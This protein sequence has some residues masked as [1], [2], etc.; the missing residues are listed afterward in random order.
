MTKNVNGVSEDFAASEKYSSEVKEIIAKNLIIART[1]NN[2]TQEELAQRA[3]I[4]RYT[5][6]QIENGEGDPKL[7]T[8]SDIASA[9][10]FSVALLFLGENE[11][12]AIQ[13][14]NNEQAE[15]FI[16][17]NISPEE[18]KQLNK[19]SKSTLQK[20]HIKAA[21]MGVEAAQKGGLVP[22]KNSEVASAAAGAAAGAAIG[23]ILLPGI[24]TAIGAA[25]GSLFFYNFNNKPSNEGDKKGGS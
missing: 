25:I 23:T 6:V 15:K 4:S 16:N 12:K 17:E 5:I 21:R 20:N 9:L 7:S 19:L 1:V 10:G 18:L 11:F 22:A 3:G 2:M 24:G 14:M 13:T 8:L